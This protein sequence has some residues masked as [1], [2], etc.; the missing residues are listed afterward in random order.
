MSENVFQLVREKEEGMLSARSEKLTQFW[1]HTD[2]VCTIFAFILPSPFQLVLKYYE[3]DPTSFATN[4][5]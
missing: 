2:P 1:K 5:S 3:Y 4:E